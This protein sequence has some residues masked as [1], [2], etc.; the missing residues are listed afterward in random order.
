MGEM[1]D[2]KS[3]WGNKRLLF[4]GFR[5]DF[6]H[7][8]KWNKASRFGR[9]KSCLFSGFRLDFR[10]GAEWNKASRFGEE[11]RRS[12]KESFCKSN[13]EERFAH[14]RE[15]CDSGK[16]LKRG[17]LKR[18]ILIKTPTSGAFGRTSAFRPPPA[19]FN[20]QASKGRE[21]GRTCAVSEAESFFRPPF[22]PP[23]RGGWPSP[24]LCTR[25]RRPPSCR[26]VRVWSASPGRS[27]SR[28]ASAP[29][30][31]R[32]FSQCTTTGTCG[33]S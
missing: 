26:R 13:L 30:S 1:A 17:L 29:A 10:H 20:R 7:A 16:P 18:P 19:Y 14:R 22:S 25:S 5:L 4:S 12:S 32:P 9:N 27:R 6:R 11:K 31:P 21:T 24:R 33:S 2:C 3:I 28:S 8:R 23:T 15:I